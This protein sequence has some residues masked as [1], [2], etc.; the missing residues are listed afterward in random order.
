MNA[1][2]AAYSHNYQQLPGWV[3]VQNI[4]RK[5]DTMAHIATLEKKARQLRQAWEAYQG[6]FQPW[7]NENLTVQGNTHNDN[8]DGPS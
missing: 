7:R 4:E 5:V 3:I 2:Q 1:I 8:D 6:I